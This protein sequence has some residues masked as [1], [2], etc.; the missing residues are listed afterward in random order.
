MINQ[1]SEIYGKVNHSVIFTDCLIEEGAIVID[2]VI[3][4]KSII[5][6]GAYI[7]RAIVAPGVVVEENRIINK[8]EDE[9]VLV[10]R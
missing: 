9:I 5:K 8:G 10:E 6:K 4:P 2:S 1:G 7:N 3:M